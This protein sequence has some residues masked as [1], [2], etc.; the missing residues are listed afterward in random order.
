MQ[1]DREWWGL[2]RLDKHNLAQRAQPLPT[3]SRRCHR[4]GPTVGESSKLSRKAGDLGFQIKNPVFKCY[5][6][7][8]QNL[9][10]STN[11]LGSQATIYTLC[12]RVL[13]SLRSGCRCHVTPELRVNPTRPALPRPKEQKQPSVRND[14]PHQLLEIGRVCAAC[15]P[16]SCQ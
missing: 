12:F 11:W 9:N 4:E 8:L 5:E 3:S 16:V 10:T 1:D 13:K 7:I 14:N 2:G 15:H 6:T